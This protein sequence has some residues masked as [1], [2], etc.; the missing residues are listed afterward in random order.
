MAIKKDTRRNLGGDGNV[1]HL[2]YSVYSVLAVIMY[3]A[4][5]CHYWKLG[6]GYM[7]SLFITVL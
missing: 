4:G 1:L 5:H 7:E 2:D 3:C 6:K